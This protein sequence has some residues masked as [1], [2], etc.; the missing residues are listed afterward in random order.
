MLRYLLATLRANEVKMTMT[1]VKRSF[2]RTTF[3][4]LLSGDVVTTIDS[5]I[6]PKATDAPTNTFVA[7]FCITL[8]YQLKRYS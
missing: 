3:G 7:I 2:N 1:L 5:P 4:P 6:I 8:A